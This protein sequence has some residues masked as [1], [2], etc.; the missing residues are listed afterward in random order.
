MAKEKVAS[1]DTISS[2]SVLL[3]RMLVWGE[4]EHNGVITENYHFVAHSFH[5]SGKSWRTTTEA[6]VCAHVCEQGFPLS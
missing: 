3:D 2:I 4:Y 6:S 5:N 1:R